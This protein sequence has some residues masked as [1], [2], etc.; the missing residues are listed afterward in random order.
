MLERDRDFGGLPPDAAVRQ[1]IAD[2]RSES[3]RLYH[4]YIGTEHLVLALAKH[5]GMRRFCHGST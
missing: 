3:D 2:P 5:S 4:E 1:L